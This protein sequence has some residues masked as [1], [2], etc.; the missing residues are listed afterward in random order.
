MTETPRRGRNRTLSAVAVLLL[1]LAL[2]AAFVMRQRAAEREAR[3]ESELRGA[4]TRLR[5]GLIAYAG[6]HHR[7]PHALSDLVR[8]KELPALPRDPITGSDATWR[9]TLEESVRIDDFQAA[10]APAEAS[11]ITAVHSGASGRDT[12]GRPWSDY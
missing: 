6:R 3:R 2:S 10:G 8:D 12:R 7:N 11:R 4:L 1:V 9:L 5:G